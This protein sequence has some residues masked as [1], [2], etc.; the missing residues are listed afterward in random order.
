MKTTQ[1]LKNDYKK[2]ASKI[3]RTILATPASHQSAT[4]AQFIHAHTA[5]MRL[6]SYAKTRENHP[7][8]II[9]REFTGDAIEPVLSQAQFF[10][11]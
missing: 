6:F 7:Q 10:G 5:K 11:K 3:N 4:Y 2:I 1:A 8:Q 9:G